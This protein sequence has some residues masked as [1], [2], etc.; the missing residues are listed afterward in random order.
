M[1]P[2]ITAANITAFCNLTGHSE[3]EI[4]W[5]VLGDEH[6]YGIFLEVLVILYCFAAL[7]I[8]CD[9]YMAT[10][11]ETLC[12]RWNIREDVA[13][14]TFLAIGSAAPEI[15][16]NIVSTI[17][18]HTS[19]DPEA[20]Q[21]GI[22]AILGSGMVAFLLAPGTCAVSAGAPLRLKR[23]PLMR[24]TGFY[25]ISVVCLV[26]FFYDGIIYAYEAG[27]L[28]GLYF[29]YLLV[30]IFSPKI[31]ELWR[32]KVQGKARRSKASFVSLQKMETNN[33]SGGGGGGGDSRFSINGGGGGGGGNSSSSSNLGLANGEISE[34]R[35]RL[36]PV[37]E[38]AEALLDD[39]PPMWESD[40]AAFASLGGES[41]TDDAIMGVLQDSMNM[42]TLSKAG[43][44]G[45]GGGGGDEEDSKP[46]DNP[47][48]RVLWYMA[49]YLTAPLRLMFWLTCP[50]ASEGSKYERWYPVTVLASFCWVAAFSFI[51]STI[52]S[53]WS[54]LLG[55]PTIILGMTLV[56]LGGEIP[57]CIQSVSVAKRGYGSLAVSNCVG[58]KVVNI[59]VGLGV[60][61]LLSTLV[62]DQPVIVCGNIDLFTASLFHAGA[63]VLF[64][65]LTLCI[66]WATGANKAFLG[67]GKGV[68]LLL[69]YP[70]VLGGYCIYYFVA[71]QS[72]P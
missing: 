34:A 57:D 54:V 33:N 62:F 3:S 22:S 51:L 27:L 18:T 13:G 44:R 71:S 25:T 28:I 23:R 15:V 68:I 9:Q 59:G 14:A 16:I 55:L 46:P 53:R 11:L 61:W 30:T 64:F 19:Q 8:V 72:P 69:A 39:E 65:A 52:I 31:R 49:G 21:L 67:R 5:S 48:L 37:D 1:S 2:S 70:A 60:P 43:D 20:I 32:V 24:D 45:G 66:A 26:I 4:D 36:G 38:E 42:S 12:L 58:S 6:W 10:A 17:R 56:A 47:I 7:A 35:A 50:D 29:V 41:I 40:P 63:I